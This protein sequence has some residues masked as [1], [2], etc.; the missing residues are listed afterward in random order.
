MVWTEFHYDSNAMGVQTTTNVLLSGPAERKQRENRPIPTPYLLHGLSDDHS[1]WT[2]MPSIE[3]YARKKY[4]AVVMPAVNRLHN[5]ADSLC[6]TPEKVPKMYI[7][8]GTE[9]DLPGADDAFV[10]AYQKK[11]DNVW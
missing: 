4:L 9:D 11:L 6:D 8:C 1:C 7:S 10:Q 5:L 2:R 3:R